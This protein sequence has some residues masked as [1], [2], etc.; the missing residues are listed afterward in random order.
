MPFVSFL[1][2]L[3]HNLF[4]T[5]RLDNIATD[6]REEQDYS[7]T[8][9]TCTKLLGLALLISI[10]Q[11]HSKGQFSNVGCHVKLAYILSCHLHPC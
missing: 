4:T 5:T 6:E 3:K 8:H 10:L 1:D 7:P 9:Q 2:Y 11:S